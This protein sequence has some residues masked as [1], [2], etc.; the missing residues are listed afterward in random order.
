MAFGAIGIGAALT[1][2]KPCPPGDPDRSAEIDGIRGAALWGNHHLAPG[3]Q[4]TGGA[5]HILHAAGESIGEQ[6][7]GGLRGADGGPGAAF[8]QKR[9]D[10][11]LRY[12]DESSP[13]SGDGSP[14]CN[15][16]GS[17]NS[18]RSSGAARCG[19]RSGRRFF[20]Y[21]AKELPPS[22]RGPRLNPYP[23]VYTLRDCTN[24]PVEYV[25]NEYSRYKN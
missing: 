17:P 16:E 12:S 25:L 15:I 2:G 5:A 4:A 1:L 19:V 6:A 23:K 7:T 3:S 22:A 24:S 11:P 14:H 13:R 9:D 10:E 21:L 18:S 20:R 8:S